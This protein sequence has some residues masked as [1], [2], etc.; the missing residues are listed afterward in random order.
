MNKTTSTHNKANK[1][2]GLTIGVKLITTFL[3]F[4]LVLGILLVLLYQRYVPS[5][6]SNQVDL[7]ALSIAKSFSSAVLEPMVIR[8]YLRVNKIA[9]VT[10]QLPDVAYACVI[11]KRGIPIAGI[12][13][14]L[15]RFD[16]NFASLVKHEG[17]PRNLVKENTLHPEQEM[18]SKHLE[19]GSQEVY[20]L[21]LPLGNTGGEIHLG[22]FVE[23]VNQAV[24]DSLIPLLILLLLMAILGVVAILFVSRT[25]SKPIQELTAQAH[26]ISMGQLNRKMNV[27]G[28]GEIGE[29]AESFNRMQ[30]SIV[31]SLKH[32]KEKK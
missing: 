2:S 26:A 17:F 1:P 20:D 22:L 19:V 5:L 21:A 3:T 23:D 27:S 14:D 18:S 10:V 28:G 25:V 29:L 8:N 15:D 32:M 12:F 11:N 13:G 7:R 4:I 6:V 31:Y 24:Q 30:A 9:E 16:P